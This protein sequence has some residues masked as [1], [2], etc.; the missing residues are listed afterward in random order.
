MRALPILFAVLAGCAAAGSLEDRER[1]AL[2][3]DLA[4]RSAGEPRRC[5]PAVQGVSLNAVDRR[6][7]V[8]DTPGTLYVS[9]LR[10]DCPSL[11]PDST[12]VVEAY[13]DQYCANDRIRALDPGTTIPG[14]LC[15]L[16]EFTPYRRPR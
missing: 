6:T 15:L 14:P 16:G 8:Y 4:G 13:G 1:T 2:A 3:R 9:R 5:V 12:I 10:T 11:R 7:L